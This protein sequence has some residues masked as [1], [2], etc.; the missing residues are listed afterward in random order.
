MRGTRRKKGIE[1]CFKRAAVALLVIA[2]LFQ[3]IP[4]TAGSFVRS[5]QAAV[6]TTGDYID[7]EKT[8]TELFVGGD[9]GWG[10][11]HATK[12]ES[13]TKATID[14]SNFGIG[15]MEWTLQY[16]VKDM[17][18]KSDTRY[19]VEFDIT[20]SI[21]KDIFIKLDDEGKYINKFI[22]LK[23]GEKYQFKEVNGPGATSSAKPY[24]FFA[25][26]RN[27][28]EANDLNGI[29]TIENVRISEVTAGN[30]IDLG[31]Q[32]TELFVGGDK[33]WGGSHA[34]KSES[35]TKAT[36]DV[37]NF[38]VG[39]M[40]WTLQYIVKDMVL[41]SDTRYLAEF[42]ITSSIDKDIFIKLDDEGKYINK[43]IH[44][45]AGEKYQF[46]EVSGPGA[47]SPAKP[48]LFFALGRNGSEANDL[49]G[50]VTIENV[51]V[52]AIGEETTPETAVPITINK[53]GTGV[54]FQLAKDDAVT[55]ANAHYAVCDSEEE[56]NALSVSGSA[57]SVSGSAFKVC[58]M[59]KK[60]NG[61][62]EGSDSVSLTNGQVICYYFDK[63]GVT[64]TPVNY[65]VS[66]FAAV[67]YTYD[68]QADL[69]T[70]GY[71]R[72]WSDEFDGTALDPAKW[73]FQIGTKDPNGGP[74]YWGNQEKQYY[75][76]TNHAVKDGKLVITAK[77]ESKEGMSYTSTRIRTKT[78]DGDILY[79][80]KYGRIEA[81]MKLPTEEGLWPAFWM[82]PADTS[83]YGTWAASGELDIMEAR[84]RV[85]EKVGGTLHFG[86]QWP[87]NTYYGKEQTFAS[88]TDI[89]AYHLYSVEW[90]PGKITWL[91]DDVPYFSTGNFWSKDSGSA[92][93][94]AYG[95]P[96][97]VPFY[98]VFNL[99]VGGTF[100]GEADL[101]NATFPA[102]M[103]VDYV[104][105][106]KKSDAY[107]QNLEDNLTAPETNR[108]K[109]SFESPAYQPTGVNG[110]YIKDTGF[111]YLNTN[112]VANVEPTSADWQ[113]F[114]GNFGGEAT[115]AKDT[116]EGKDYAKASI[117]K[118]GSFNYA[119]Q[120]IKHIPFASGY[121]YEISFD[122]KASAD[123]DFLL[124]PCGD[125]DNGWTGYGVSKT[126]G[127]TTAMK[128]YTHQF[129]MDKDSDPTARLEFDLGLAAGDVWIGNVVVKQ[130]EPE[131]VDTTDIFKNPDQNGGNHIYN[132]SF[133]QGAGRLAFWH[134]EN[135]AVKVPSVL[136]PEYDAAAG[137]KGDFSRRVLVTA[138][139]T[140]ARIY[141]KGIWL[142]QS[143]IYG[144]SL[145]LSSQAA[146]KVLAVLTNKDGSKVYMK[147]GIDV[148][149]TGTG[150]DYKV[151][152]AMSKGVTDKEALFALVFEKGSTVSVDNIRLVRT[153][154]NN[155]TIDY[156]DVVLE[157]VKTDSTGWTNNL[158]N[159]GSVTPATNENEEITSQTVTH[160]LNYMSMLY[161]PVSV[162][163]GITYKLSFQAQSEHNN[164]VMVNIQEDNTWA[165]TL[166]KT[167]DLNAGE[168]KQFNY[169]INSTL[170]NGTN[171]IFLKFLL[172]GPNVTPGILKVKNVSMT[173]EVPEGAKD[174][175]ADTIISGTAPVKGS[176]YVIALK[177][178][179]YKTKFLNS[180]EKPDR[181]A[182]VMV[183]GSALPDGSV[184]N[185]TIV[186][187]ASI[188]GTGAYTIE[189]A[190]D[191]F[192]CIVLT[193]TVRD[194]SNPGGN[195]GGSSGNDPSE[196]NKPTTAPTS[197]PTPSPKPEDSTPV[198]VHVENGAATIV[199]ELDTADSMLV[200]DPF[201]LLVQINNE[202]VDKI[203]IEAR[204]NG[205]SV[206]GLNLS[207]A[208]LNAAKKNQKPISYIVNDENGK[209]RYEFTMD[210]DSLAKASIQD[211]LSLGVAI[212]KASENKE[213]Q[214]ILSKDKKN[215]DGMLLDFAQAGE[216]PAQAGIRLQVG[217]DDYKAGQKVYLYAVNAKTGKLE[218][219]PFGTT[220][221][222][223]KDGYVEFPLIK[224]GS[225]VI[226]SDQPSKNVIT[227]LNAQINVEQTK[228]LNKGTK[229]KIK[230]S[231]P[232]TLE[233]VG[234]MKEKASFSAKGRA[235]ITHQSSNTSVAKIDKNGTVTG[236]K[237]GVVTI[238][239]K[240]K[241]Y[242]G[243]TYTYKTK[244]TVK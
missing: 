29:V 242:T 26:G 117:T 24:L 190:L 146:T 83:I 139:D 50:I 175:P 199:A 129:T 75:T 230:V 153:T 37:S 170:T 71:T 127:L 8:E 212:G 244:V 133:D 171:P 6:T 215:P 195:Q 98:L 151:N 231:L 34:T 69:A 224:G 218:S 58:T 145:N 154:N 128:H 149:G 208:V 222:V 17:V 9:K 124:K 99:A 81:R 235:V 126:V 225:Y 43:F 79:A 121:T 204:T 104:R 206:P 203:V 47:T 186:I 38:G 205:T 198:E 44:L 239:T 119:I 226:L 88:S 18:L 42:D 240:V 40:E 164:S 202:D 179:D 101:K 176:D 194:A 200:I 55:T 96:F 162:K 237:P 184:K 100:D 56:A 220:Y 138:D 53:K 97:D 41:K 120:L 63:N 144:L 118:G 201:T 131:K 2:M 122:A 3:A 217:T 74:D 216:F 62:W 65:T 141:Q 185:G 80:A 77:Q 123:R 27:G 15:E 85:P 209:T 105:V 166:E 70:A 135:A 92:E 73:S 78:D 60:A 130:V 156:S 236:N 32:E 211:S 207:K 132:G 84:G 110:D 11:S 48:Y 167:L 14:V 45:K 13:G 21:D 10:G 28:S 89:G 49:N 223:D 188:L 33:G 213:V 157:P 140:N 112:G 1:L 16:I 197:A 64:T 148:A 113:F 57:V 76:D 72:V 25:L 7:L 174:A 111:S 243:K 102:D 103:E 187:P 182:L 19:L 147:Q 143:D 137:D 234:S 67:D 95:A 109:A 93:N 68:N 125:E 12:S 191:G 134:T 165:V 142:Q 46:S 192:N 173:A 115:V 232:A 177:D 229:K 39:E 228:N 30:Y 159:G 61:I 86:S 219:V 233:K 181:K 90:E 238:T 36:I 158:N 4:G 22:H 150:K 193:G 210:T 163:K 23:A 35:G 107:Y 221:R 114:V 82:L 52:S 51:K 161:V 169:T 172:S 180:V 241:L 108:D 59:S 66:I 196:N 106:Y 227:P 116:I 136:H 91:V 168:W 5:A 155:V 152:F 87:N 189:L 20:S 178:G 160:Q 214:K 94:Y 54:T 31:N 183:N